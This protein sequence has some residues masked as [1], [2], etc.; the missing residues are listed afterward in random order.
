MEDEQSIENKIFFIRNQR[1]MLDSD[2]AIIYGVETR[3]LNEQFKRNESRFP[4]DFAFRLTP[5][6]W[7]NL[8]SQIATSSAEQPYITDSTEDLSSQEWG[9][10]RKM[11]IVFTEHGSV[12]LASVLNSSNAVE[13]SIFVVRA[14]IRF[15]HMFNTQD[16]LANKILQ[17]EEKFDGQF[18]VVFDALKNLFEHPPL[19]KSRQRIGY[20]KDQV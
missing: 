11:P 13:A 2:L 15:R 6:E 1:V 9:G 17:L 20:K 19:P 10:R 5:A 14:F 18:N 3:R 7:L 8:K 4:R 12:M 16:Q